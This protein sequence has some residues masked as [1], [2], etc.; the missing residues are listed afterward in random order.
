[1][2]LLLLLLL[3]RL[4]RAFTALGGRFARQPTSSTAQSH[5]RTHA[6][7]TCS[8]P[9]PTAQNQTQTN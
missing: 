1:M 5:A 2:L 6:E 4:L 9:Q 7:T 8:R 3:L